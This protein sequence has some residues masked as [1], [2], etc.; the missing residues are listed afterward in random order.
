[1]RGSFAPQEKI[2]NSRTAYKLRLRAYTSLSGDG[3]PE[4]IVHPFMVLYLL[5]S[6]IK[7][8]YHYHEHVT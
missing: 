5:H 4:Y 2:E 3:E 7:V 8:L 1:M 6:A